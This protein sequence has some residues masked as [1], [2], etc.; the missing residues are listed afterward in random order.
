LAQLWHIKIRIKLAEA[1]FF[2]SGFLAEEMAIS[3]GTVDDRWL[4]HKQKS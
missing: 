2:G 4:I 1:Q 3:G